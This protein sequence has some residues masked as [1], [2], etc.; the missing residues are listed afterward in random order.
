MPDSNV[1]HTPTPTVVALA[2][3]RWCAQLSLPELAGD[4]LAELV[5]PM[6]TM[7]SAFHSLV[8]AMSEWMGDQSNLHLQTVLAGALDG[9]ESSWM[10]LVG[11]DA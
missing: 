7:T 10:A 6:D 3:L 1:P 4:A 5:E 2:R 8:S 9:F 11:T